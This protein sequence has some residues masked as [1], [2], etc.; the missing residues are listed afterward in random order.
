MKDSITVYSLPTCPTCNMLKMV[1]K[2]RGVE[3]TECQDEA[4]MIQ[5]GYT[6]PPTLVIVDEQG[7][8]VF[9]KKEAIDYIKENY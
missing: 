2:Q 3:F 4:L 9:R 7:E 1:M 5:L 6:Q 8:H